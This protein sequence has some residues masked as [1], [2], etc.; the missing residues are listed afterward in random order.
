VGKLM[1]H[2]N[3]HRKRHPSLSFTT[4]FPS[5]SP[6]LPSSPSPSPPLYPSAHTLV[7][8]A[9]FPPSTPPVVRHH[10]RLSKL[11]LLVDFLGEATDIAHLRQ[12]LCIKRRREG[13][14][15]GR[16]GDNCL[17]STPRL[18]HQ[19][20]TTPAAHTLL[21]N[22][23]L[24]PSYSLFNLFPPSLPPSLHAPPAQ[25]TSPQGELRGCRPA[26]HPHKSTRPNQSSRCC[27]SA[28]QT[29]SPRWP[30]TTNRAGHFGTSPRADCLA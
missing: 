28:H 4:H 16:G 29:P 8:G 12:D 24:S 3:I 10:L 18:T 19:P 13:G 17:A 27:E 11:Q 2:L 5:S 7:Q 15:E 9:F 20:N 6:S 1:S 23:S 21:Q 22:T 14:R 30:C 26:V 25:Y